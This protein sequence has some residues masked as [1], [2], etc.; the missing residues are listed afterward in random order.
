VGENRTRCITVI[1]FIT[2][3]PRSSSPRSHLFVHRERNQS[4]HPAAS[5]QESSE[6]VEAGGQQVRCGSG[7]RT[8]AVLFASS[9]QAP[10]PDDRK[11][12]EGI[13]LSVLHGQQSAVPWGCCTVEFFLQVSLGAESLRT[14]VEGPVSEPPEQPR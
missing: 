10:V 7:T 2:M 8:K 11:R 14:V 6:W 1:G 4:P 3:D 12:R 13:Q 5:Q 9:W